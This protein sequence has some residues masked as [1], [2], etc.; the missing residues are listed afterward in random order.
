[1]LGLPT[2]LSVART[3]MTIIFDAILFD[4][5]LYNPLFNFLS[6]LYFLIP[7]AKRKGKKIVY[8]NVG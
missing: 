8:Y 4:R 2:F 5:A 3:D 1:M 7:F 6:T